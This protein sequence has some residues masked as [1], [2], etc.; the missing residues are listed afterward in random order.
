[1]NWRFWTYQAWSLLLLTRPHF[2][3]ASVLLFLS[4]ALS[5][6]PWSD[7]DT[8]TCAVL[9]AVVLVQLSAGLV[10]EYS[11]WRG[12]RFSRRSLFSGGSGVLATG[13]AMPG[14]ALGMAI[15]SAILALVLGLYATISREGLVLVLPLLLLGLLLAWSY[16]LP[17]LRY[18]NTGLGELAVAFLLAFYLPFLAIYSVGGQG[19]GFL[20]YSMVLFP[21]CYAMIVAVQLPD[22]QADIRSG[23]SNLTYRIGV[24]RA[25]RVMT[26]SAL[27]GMFLALPLFL[28]G[29]VEWP[30]LL[31]LSFLP[32]VIWSEMRLGRERYY[33]HALAVLVTYVYVVELVLT[34]LLVLLSQTI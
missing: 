32:L 15:G 33:E 22:K 4:G 28:W 26:L 20:P 6:I 12:D 16:S 3:L 1:M 17:P 2:L 13:W 29:K 25:L 9:A 34:M 11:D 8:P 30:L 31:T 18:V 23:K 7:M 21:F 27:I 19:M 14:T 5:Q 10:N 24:R